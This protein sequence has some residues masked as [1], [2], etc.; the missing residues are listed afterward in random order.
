MKY[1]VTILVVG[2]ISFNL[3]AQT[4]Q[5]T[6]LDAQ[7]LKPVTNVN[8]LISNQDIGTNTNKKGKFKIRFDKNQKMNDTIVFSHI[9]YNTV[10]KSASSFKSNDTIF[11]LKSVHELD[12]VNFT[13]K[14]PL[15][16]TLQYYQMASMN[17]PAHSFS[18]LLHEGNI[19]VTGGDASFRYQGTIKLLE[20]YPDIS[21]NELF[22]K[23]WLNHANDKFLNGLKFYD[24]DRD[25]WII[26]KVGLSKRA[27]H[28]SW[29]YKGKLYVVGGKELSRTKKR[30]Y[31]KTTIEIVDFENDSVITD[32][33]NPHTAVDFASFLYKNKLVVL[34]GSTKL[35]R[36]GTKE[37]SD[38]MHLYDLDS[39]YWYE[40]GRMPVPKE[41]VGTI[42]QDKMYLIGGYNG[43]SLNSIESYDLISQKWKKEGTLFEG[44]SKP[45][46]AD[47]GVNIYIYDN[48]KMSVFNTIT[49]ELSQYNI[50]LYL[51]ASKMI[52]YK[53]RLIILGGI[54]PTHYSLLPSEAVY[55]VDTR[56]FDRTS[57]AKTKKI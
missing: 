43:K 16:K 26:K 39:G 53:K 38:K 44:I 4:I 1:L 6:V 23:S 14:L 46:I 36:N 40:L 56:E 37:Y 28:N 8:V 32:Q 31:L 17:K 22:N 7:S 5:G 51:K 47:D 41:T 2:F 54:R 11:M 35:N 33:T 25:K 57:I 30:E 9:S 20:D 55:S 21:F 13:S 19:V 49:R 12:E 18:A 45:A 29:F 27:Y 52:Y 15:R 3:N 48:G 24:I 34:G 50:E 10:F 42:V